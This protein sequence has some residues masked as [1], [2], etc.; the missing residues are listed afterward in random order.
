MSKDGSNDRSIEIANARF[1][2][3]GENIPFGAYQALYHKVTKK[4]EKISQGYEKAYEIRMADLSELNQRL[5]Q[6]LQQYRVAGKNCEVSH[7]LLD[8]QSRLYS[9]FQKFDL[10]DCSTRAIT[11]AIV[12]E[13]NFL[14]VRP[15]EIPEAEDVPQ[16]YKI[17]LRIENSIPREE[18]D[19][20]PYFIRLISGDYSVNLVVEYADYAVALAIKSIVDKWIESLPSKEGAR[21]IRF[22]SRNRVF[23]SG[24][25][26]GFIK[27]IP[28]AVAT[29][30]FVQ[31][32]DI[33][34]QVLFSILSLAL[35]LSYLSS[36]LIGMLSVRMENSIDGL[37]PKT[38]LIVTKGDQDN[39]KIQSNKTYKYVKFFSLGAGAIVTILL[40]VFS[41]AIYSYLVGK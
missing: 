22:L 15:A 28:F 36:T 16:R 32:P 23:I 9:S 7:S 31:N 12:Y 13:L 35:F 4:T 37:H 27:A 39:Y 41:S 8:S 18:N 38:L 40:N 11:K 1:V 34:T 10:S 17:S 14:I 2:I 19:E 3:D 6:G 5:E 29:I 26:S 25:V 24:Y 30:F 33:E 20:I 21:G